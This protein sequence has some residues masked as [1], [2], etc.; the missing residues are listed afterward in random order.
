[1]LRVNSAPLLLFVLA[2]LTFNVYG[3]TVK[4]CPLENQI[5]KDCG[6]ACPRNCEHLIKPVGFCTLNCVPGCF[7]CSPY[8]FQS[9]N[10]G[11]CVLP[12][13]CPGFIKG[14]GAGVPNSP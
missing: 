12:K 6:T 7:C 10:T 3:Y 14:Y 4:R 8:I 9:G 1:M 11:S 13:Q 2:L 5:W